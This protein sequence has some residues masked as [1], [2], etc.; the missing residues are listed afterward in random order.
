MTSAFDPP[1][2]NS[3]ERTRSA[4]VAR[5]AARRWW[6]AAQFMIRWAAVR[7]V[8]KVQR[9]LALRA[10]VFPVFACRQ[11]PWSEEAAV[12]SQLKCGMLPSEVERIAAIANAQF[13]NQ[14]PCAYSAIQKYGGSILVAFD[15]EPKLVFAARDGLTE[16]FGERGWEWVVACQDQV[17]NC[18]VP[19]TPE[20]P[21]S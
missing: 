15:G 4:A 14:G 9:G 2:N 8:W 12:A 3:F 20:P 10:L 16:A 11:F 13:A 21:R 17:K 5:F 1:P 6:R 7:R 18:P 19:I